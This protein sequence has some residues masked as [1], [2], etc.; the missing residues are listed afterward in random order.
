MRNM[1]GIS[2]FYVCESKFFLLALIFAISRLEVDANADWPGL[3]GPTR[4]GL[5]DSSSDIPESISGT[6]KQIWKVEAEHERNY[7]QAGDGC[8][9]RGGI[10]KRVIGGKQI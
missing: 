10:F 5:A 7:A 1:D 9:W 4:N 2:R 3:L 8:W 6:P